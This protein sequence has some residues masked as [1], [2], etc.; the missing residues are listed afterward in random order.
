MNVVFSCRDLLEEGKATIPCLAERL[1]SELIMHICVSA[2]R[3]EQ[4]LASAELNH[5]DTHGPPGHLVKMW[6]QIQGLWM[7]RY[8]QGHQGLLAWNFAGRTGKTALED[9]G[10]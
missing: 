1:T 8:E 5:V 3:A 4:S 2:R 7:W 9:L 10:P 6:A